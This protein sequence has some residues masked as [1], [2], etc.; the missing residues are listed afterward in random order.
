MD[1]FGIERNEIPKIVV[2]GLRLRKTPIWLLLRGVNNVGKLDGILDE[3]NRDVV[4][5]QI[6]VALFGVKFDCK[7]SD[8]ACEVRRPFIARNR[9][10]AH[11]DRRLLVR[12]LKQICPRYVAER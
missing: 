10:K 8:V 5:N 4:S 2:G 1:T 6:P 9:R 3:K 7:T 11:E 12:P